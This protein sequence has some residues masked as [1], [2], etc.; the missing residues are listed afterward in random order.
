MKVFPPDE[1][2]VNTTLPILIADYQEDWSPASQPVDNIAAT[3]AYLFWD[4]IAVIN[5]NSYQ[6]RAIP[7]F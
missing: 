7:A 5:S 3:A 4:Q 1:T 6:L 2:F